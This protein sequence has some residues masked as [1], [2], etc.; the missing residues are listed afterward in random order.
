M[1]SVGYGQLNQ[2]VAPTTSH[3]R[4]PELISQT[5]GGRSVGFC[6]TTDGSSKSN[7]YSPL[8]SSLMTSAMR[9]E[10]TAMRLQAE[11]KVKRVA[12][13][14]FVLNSIAS[15]SSIELYLPSFEELTAWMENVGCAPPG[16]LL[17]VV[18]GPTVIVAMMSTVVMVSTSS[19]KMSTDVMVAVDAESVMVAI[20]ST[21]VRVSTSIG[22]ISTD[23]DV[24]VDAGSVMSS[25]I[26][27][28]PAVMVTR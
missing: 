9:L 23:I 6:A 25:V 28:P 10:I 1:K 15:L 13:A 17:Q 27:E 11:L 3:C 8:I 5:A 20:M 21:V 14:G 26:V 4:N 16:I 12:S 24:I 19:V 7:S 2:N 18:V 22:I